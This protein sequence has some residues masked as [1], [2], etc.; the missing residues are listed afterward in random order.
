MALRWQQQNLNETSHSQQPPHTSPSRASYGVSILRIMKKI[1]H[2]ITALD[3]IVFIIVAGILWLSLDKDTYQQ[4]GLNGKPSHFNHKVPRKFGMWKFNWNKVST[5][6]YALE[7]LKSMTPADKNMMI[8]II[9]IIIIKKWGS[10]Q[11]LRARLM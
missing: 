10:Y 3:C 9:L 6:I 5:K 7:S 11:W 8:I 1:D 4:L 2:V